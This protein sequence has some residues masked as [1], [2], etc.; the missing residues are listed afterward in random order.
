[1]LTPIA[2]NSSN[3][4]ILIKGAT[5]VAPDPKTSLPTIQEADV[6]IHN[7]KIKA[8]GHDLPPCERTIKA[9]G[10][11]L[12]PGAIDTQVHFREPG[13]PDKETLSSG[14][15][16]A[17]FG[18]V[19]SIFDMPNTNPPTLSAIDV[20]DKMSRASG[21]TWCNYAFYVGASPTN[22]DRL[23]D[24]ENLPGVC[25][26]K[27]FMGSST[28]NLVVGED[29]TISQALKNGRRR[30]AIH[31]EDE[32][33]LKERKHIVLEKRG[34]V[35]LHP[36]WRDEEVALIATRKILA[37]SK[38]FS[39]PVHIL[40][41]SSAAEVAELQKNK[42]NA[43]FEV[44]PQHLTLSAPECY[45]RL[46]TFAQMNPPIRDKRHQEALWQ[47]VTSGLA[48]VLGSDHAPH[49]RTEKKLV[50]PDS[51]SGMTGVQTMLPLML[52]H[53]VNGKL[54]LE[55]VVEL[56]AHNPAK[57]F[58]I[59]SKGQIRVGFDADLTLVDLKADKKI[60]NNW[61]QSQ[62]GWTPFDEMKINA[63]VIATIVGGN[64]VMRDDQ[65]LG[66]P[67]GRPV[68]FALETSG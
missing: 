40:H 2:M 4:D 23:G 62:C 9:K 49:T 16:G 58:N 41:V 17:V 8:I 37:L 51:P 43:S 7:G 19:T 1:M 44:T 65:E 45:E 20:A 68:E 53:A 28:G 22:V 34:H 54:K 10:L 50:Y 46:G 25:G 12:L 29:D 11:H 27:M 47:A 61:I 57:I 18:G 30:M 67:C 33:R 26:V 38:K 14:T 42:G 36:V 24:L 52:H 59:K 5:I 48:D 13:Y 63:W 3:A 55:R 32:T 15:R 21:T 39:R 31:A 66:T 60:T 6:A 64:I 56:L 35:E